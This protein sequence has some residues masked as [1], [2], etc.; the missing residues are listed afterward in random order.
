M[1]ARGEGHAPLYYK[2]P[3]GARP[4]GGGT[5]DAPNDDPPAVVFRPTQF[6]W[7]NPETFPRRQFAYGRHYAR[8]FVSATI[9]TTKTGKTTLTLVEAVAM[10]SGR[11]LL[12]VEPGRPM[13]V[14]CF[15]GED[16]REEIERRVT[17]ICLH[18]RIDRKEIEG[19]LFIDSGRDTEIIVATQTRNEIAVSAQMEAALNKASARERKF[20]ARR[21]CLPQPSQGLVLR[22]LIKC[23]M[24][25]IP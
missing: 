13:K 8:R 15:N 25:G 7:R 11:N 14:W 3:P 9:A 12:G 20:F 23:P 21:R 5:F 19:N 18:C 10:A 1:T 4:N 16:P 17:G 22:C 24:P 2:A 6:K